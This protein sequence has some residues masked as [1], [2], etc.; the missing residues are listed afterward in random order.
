[1]I[2]NIVF[3]MAWVLFEYRPMD[4]L[5]K[6]L[7]EQDAELV[8]RELFCA[9]EWIETDRGTLSDA[10]Y[11]AGV[12]R[13]LPSRLHAMAKYLYAHWHE[14]PEPIP[15][16]ERVV[17]RMK[18]NGYGIYLLTNM[19]GRFYRFYKKIPAIRYFDGMVVSA[20]VH[21]VKPE[22]EIYLELF[23]RFG[24]RPEECFFVDDR[25]ENVQAGLELGMQGFCFRQD[26]EEL[27][28]VL[29]QAG[30]RS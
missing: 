25:E 27:C 26:V 15:A 4:F 9:P 7:S 13:R 1:M 29:R 20:D 10:D 21:A 28:A 23:R 19:S 14:M 24:L 8:N 17:G 6:Y 18:Q 22:P 5:K 11:L 16:M 3:D 2:R 12:L 30:V